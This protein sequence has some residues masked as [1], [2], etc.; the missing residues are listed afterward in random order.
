M[1]MP[2]Y[3]YVLCA[4]STLLEKINIRNEEVKRKQEV[5]IESYVLTIILQPYNTFAAQTRVIAFM[6]GR[7]RP[8]KLLL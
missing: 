5:F 4:T 2:H 7:G 3:I 1:D 8:P 6:Y